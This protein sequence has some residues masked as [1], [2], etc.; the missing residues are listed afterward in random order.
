M[1]LCARH[2]CCYWSWNHLRLYKFLILVIF[3][4]KI[5]NSLTVPIADFFYCYCQAQMEEKAAAPPP[6][7]KDAVTPTQ[8]VL[9][10]MPKSTFLRNVGMQPA[11]SKTKAG[12]VDVRVQELENELVAEKEGSAAVR[13]QV[14]DVANKLEEER[15]ARK[16]VEEDHEMLKKQIGEMHAFFSSFLRVNPAQQ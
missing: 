16:K 13:A 8:A 3:V 2:V 6:E 10:V 12:E 15:A 1:N 14:D 7:G 9:Q 5:A 11:A 4:N